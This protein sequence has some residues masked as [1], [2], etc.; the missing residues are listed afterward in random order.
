MSTQVS[1]LRMKRRRPYTGQS[2]LAPIARPSLL[3]ALE[4]GS[5]ICGIEQPDAG[6]LYGRTATTNH[7]R[8]FSVHYR[9]EELV[10]SWAVNLMK[11]AG[12]TSRFGMFER[13]G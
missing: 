11:K 7:R 6:K 8:T 5:S 1:K 9:R 13:S 12:T 10:S 3:V 2:P 4:P